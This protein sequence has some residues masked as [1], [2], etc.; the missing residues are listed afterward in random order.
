MI[1]FEDGVMFT[2]VCPQPRVRP[3]FP[4]S[5]FPSSL[6]LCLGLILAFSIANTG[7]ALLNSAG[8]TQ[9]IAI[10]ASLPVATL[11]H[12]YSAA[13]SVSTLRVN[14]MSKKPC[15][16]SQNSSIMRSDPE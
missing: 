7:C 5:Q 10:S 1:L 13:I 15:R 3:S 2:L 12:T 6:Y 8:A 9:P 11:G 16:C 14:R 4:T